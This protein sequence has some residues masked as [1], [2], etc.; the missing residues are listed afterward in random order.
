MFSNDCRYEPQNAIDGT[1]SLF[2]SQYN[3]VQYFKV[4]MEN[5]FCVQKVKVTA[6]YTSSYYDKDY[7]NYLFVFYNAI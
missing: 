3:P 7:V 4:R 6:Y 5:D 1:G 2:H